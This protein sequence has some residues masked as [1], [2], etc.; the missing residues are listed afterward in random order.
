MKKILISILVLMTGFTLIGCNTSTQET[1]EEINARISELEARISELESRID[2]LE[3]NRV[4][5][6]SEVDGEVTDDGEVFSRAGIIV[7]GEDIEAGVYNIT[8]DSNWEEWFYLFRSTE[9]FDNFDP[10]DADLW[11]TAIY[12]VSSDSGISGFILREGYILDTD[13]STFY[14]ELE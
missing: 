5:S 13:G 7:I 3:A 11:N 9:E 10:G 6:I 2:D 8:T 14:F 4:T 1:F 12:F